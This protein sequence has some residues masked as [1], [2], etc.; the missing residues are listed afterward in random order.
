MVINTNVNI[1]TYL[2]Y[3]WH[4]QT[5]WWWYNQPSYKHIHDFKTYHTR[6]LGARWATPCYKKSILGSKWTISGINFFYRFLLRLSENN[7]S[8][9]M[10][11]AK[12]GSTASDFGYEI[13]I[14]FGVE[15]GAFVRPHV[16]SWTGF[17]LFTISGVSLGPLEPKLGPFKDWQEISDFWKIS[18]KVASAPESWCPG[19]TAP[20]SCTHNFVSNPSPSTEL[21]HQLT[22]AE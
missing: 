14:I 5:L 16:W 12:F 21:D 18:L 6:S 7:H 15:I 17:D 13:L 19:C 10:F 3:P 20:I 9:V 22:H 1:F 11:I 8:R 2:P 4:F